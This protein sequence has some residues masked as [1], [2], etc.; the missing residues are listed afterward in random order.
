MHN[1]DS[2]KKRYQDLLKIIIF[3]TSWE[4]AYLDRYEL[5][6]GIN[7]F[8]PHPHA[9]LPVKSLQKRKKMK[10]CKR[11]KKRSARE[12]AGGG[13]CRLGG[14]SSSEEEWQPW[15]EERPKRRKA[16]LGKCD[17]NLFPGHRPGVE[18]PWNKAGVK[19]DHVNRSQ[20]LFLPLLA[21]RCLNKAL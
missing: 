6:L 18:W 20:D 13:R 17:S 16:S 5:K 10:Q 4:Q 7:S 1:F 9:G 14:E 2:C 8:L 12:A 15:M 21:I 11:P 19:E 3:R